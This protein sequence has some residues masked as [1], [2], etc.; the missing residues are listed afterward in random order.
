[1][2]WSLFIL[3]CYLAAY[4]APP[5]PSSAA[6]TRE[7]LLDMQDVAALTAKLHEYWWTVPLTRSLPYTLPALLHQ[8]WESFPI[9]SGGVPSSLLIATDGSG[10][11][12]GSWAF[13]VWA[14]ASPRWY[15]IGWV[16]A[17]L[18][19]TPWL[20]DHHRYEVGPLASY[21]G[22]LAALQAAGIW[23]SA[24]LDLWQ[25]HMGCRPHMITLAVDNSAALMA[26]AGHGRTS[27]AAATLARQ[28][29][30]AVQ[31]RTNT[32]FHHVHSH[33]G[34][35]A[36]SLAD[37]LAEG[38]AGR[39]ASCRLAGTP[40]V[41]TS[42]ELTRSFPSLWLLPF[43]ELS[44]GVPVLRIAEDPQV[45]PN[46]TPDPAPVLDP[47]EP[48]AP[49]ASPTP[50]HILTAN[51]QTI[52]DA[53]PSIFNPSGLAA[54]RQYLYAQ[55]AACGADVVCI[56]EARSRAG[57]WAGPN[58][59]TW[60][61][62]AHKGQYGCEVWIRTHITHPPLRFGDWRILHSSPRILCITCVAARLPLT[63]TSAHAPH[64]E[65]PDKESKLFWRE[66]ASLAR[67]APTGRALVIG[68]DANGD[69]HAADDE[70]FL[71]GD[72]LAQADP[73]RND[74][75]LLEFC[76]TTGLEAPSTFSTTQ[77][78]QGW[79]WQ[80]TSG[81]RKRLDHLLFRPGPWEH[82]SASQAFDFD[83]VNT[84]RDHVALRVRSVLTCPRPR[85]PPRA[86]ESHSS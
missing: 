58:I 38:A 23:A 59:L 34:I 6:A 14:Y 5:T 32:N 28:A 25:L 65:R 29:W 1:M 47:K 31:S 51:I 13:A 64:A 67:Q 15:R 24:Q 56:Q 52:K 21:V 74:E 9:W 16:A 66:M 2:A 11:G 76:L 61:S 7:W 69:F 27:V 55:M 22:E 62:G 18:E 44:A 83:I 37:A 42:E 70:G 10:R 72:L 84:S 46:Y 45:F 40:P 33:T 39:L 79:S 12:G 50:V 3:G 75:A 63:I 54:R 68:L 82:R 81:R 35:M 26:A 20:P 85:A 60:R 19:N 77:I 73:G 53:T 78:G 17:P 71:V 36:N 57:R 80:H 49:Q 8:S 41:L 43:C 30:Q 4:G 86:Q 48:E